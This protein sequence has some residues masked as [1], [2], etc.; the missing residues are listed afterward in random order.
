MQ[1]SS[2]PISQPNCQPNCQPYSQQNTQLAIPP[3]GENL[4]QTSLFSSSEQSTNQLQPS[5]T[6][7]TP[8]LATSATNHPKL[9]T[10][11]EVF[12]KFP[13]LH[14]LH[15]APTLAVKLA[16]YAFFGE[17]VMAACMP[18]GCRE[19]AALPADGLSALKATLLQ[20]F[21]VFWASPVEFEAVWASCVDAIGQACKRLR[22]YKL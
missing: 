20:Q 13:K 1:L 18:M 2:W 21:P 9:S 22:H 11:A 14:S 8:P 12:A 5:S 16:R 17:D 7:T 19:Y 4:T 15:K 6:R 10:A 3:A